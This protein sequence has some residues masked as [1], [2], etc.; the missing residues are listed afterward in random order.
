MK[1]RFKAMLSRFGSHLIGLVTLISIVGLIW[2]EVLGDFD[3]S[4]IPFGRLF[5]ASES[6]ESSGKWVRFGGFSPVRS[7]IVLEVGDPCRYLGPSVS[8]TT[9]GCFTDFF[10]DAFPPPTH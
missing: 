7:L 6:V 9:R 8:N 4:G 2:H 10:G 5:I 3:S 1:F